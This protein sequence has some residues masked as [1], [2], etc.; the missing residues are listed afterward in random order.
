MTKPSTFTDKEL[1]F[2]A[3]YG[4]HISYNDEV[5]AQHKAFM[6]KQVNNLVQEWVEQEK[7]KAEQAKEIS[8]CLWNA[9][10]LTGKILTDDGRL[11][12]LAQSPQLA[13]F[14]VDTH[15][16]NI[17]SGFEVPDA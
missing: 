17:M 10:T 5:N 13:K 16:Y 12:A 11:V 14:I 3:L 15:N 8:K 9:Q 2:S 6:D 4:K 7:N 1:L